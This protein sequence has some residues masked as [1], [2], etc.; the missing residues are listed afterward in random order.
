MPDLIH[1]LDKVGYIGLFLVI[2]FE[3]GVPIT[4]FL[5]GDSLLF[6]TGFLASQGHL[7][8]FILI[9]ILFVAA[10]LGYLFGYGLGKK[11][12]ETLFTREDSFWF[13]KKRLNYAREF[14]EKYGAK[15]ILLGRFVPVV[16]TFSA[17][18]AGAVGMDYRKFVL[19]TFIGGALWAI[20]VTLLGF[21]LG[22]IMPDAHLYL[23]PII[24]GIVFV[25]ILPGI[26][27]YINNQLK[28]KRVE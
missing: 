23:T 21:F 17:T 12:G 5:P 11:I 20:G 10:I 26:I 25:S 7:N 9:P 6:T 14:F 19:F 22:K 13:N 18:V 1:I 16:R 27:E 8:I 15:T 3:C 24:L 2:F 4:F 28:K